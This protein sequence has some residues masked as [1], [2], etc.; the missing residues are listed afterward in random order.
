MTNNLLPQRKEKKMATRTTNLL[1]RSSLVYGM[2]LASTPLAA[3]YLLGAAELFDNEPKV[4]ITEVAMPGQSSLATDNSMTVRVVVRDGERT[5]AVDP[6]KVAAMFEATSD[7]NDWDG[8]AKLTPAVEVLA[9]D[10]NGKMTFAV[11]PGDGTAPSAFLR[12]RK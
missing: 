3:S 5:V 4:G 9:T 11:T 10:A 7:L 12:I 8:A 1:M 6:A 2:L